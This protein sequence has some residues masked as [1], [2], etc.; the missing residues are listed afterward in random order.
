[1]RFPANAVLTVAL[2]AGVLATACRDDPPDG[3]P[4]AVVSSAPSGQTATMPDWAVDPHEPGVSLPPVGRSLFDSLVAA[5]PGEPPGYQVPFPFTALTRAIERTLEAEGSPSPLKRV[6]LPLNRSLQRNAARP[7]FFT[8]PRAVVAVDTEPQ[9]PAGRAGLMLK[10]RLFIGYQEKA[11]ILEVISYNEAAGR[12]EFQVVEDYR[13]DGRRRV[14]YAN[15]AMCVVCHQNHAPIFARA[16]WDETQANQGIAARLLAARR[17][18]YGIPPGQGV[19]VP[20][21]IDNATDRANLFSAFQRVWRDGCE[22]S[23]REGIACRAQLFTLAL[24]YRLSGARDVDRR[25][26]AYRDVVVPTL[27]RGW[28]Q[29][30]PRGLA[31]PNPDIPNRDPLAGNLEGSLEAGRLSAEARLADAGHAVGCSRALRALESTAA[32][33]SLVRGRWSRG[34]DRSRDR[35]IVVVPGGRRH[36]TPRSP[37]L[38]ARIACGREGGAVR[39]PVRL[40]G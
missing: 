16:L 38:R 36:P 24:Q 1:M 6:L 10:D 32:P 4:T 15:R 3:K 23:R 34:G 40:P 9:G 19:D 14:L 18:F 21:A 29:R 17:S 37:S 27:L 12:F 7:D 25:A 20:Y 26:A 8:Y 39:D 5:P 31:I 2:L 22:V 28:Q 11:D 13:R 33:R 35:W 30:W